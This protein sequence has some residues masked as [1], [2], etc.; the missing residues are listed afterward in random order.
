M[1]VCS[2]R[3]K[4]YKFF[5]QKWYYKVNPGNKIKGTLKIEKTGN[6]KPKE[7]VWK[8]DNKKFN[9]NYQKLK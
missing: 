9:G 6:E 4:F 5:D 8:M 2:Y 1:T 7:T 3:G